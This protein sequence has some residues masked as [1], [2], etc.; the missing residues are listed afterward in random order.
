MRTLGKPPRAKDINDETPTADVWL[1]TVNERLNYY[2]GTADPVASQVP[3][4]QW[5]VYYNSTL[6]E[7]RIWTNVNGTLK[8]SAAFT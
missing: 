8:K 6:G 3:K 7:V 5:I 2:S 4:G 1:Y